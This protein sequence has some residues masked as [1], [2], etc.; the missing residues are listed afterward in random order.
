MEESL[1][2]LIL[3][4]QRGQRMVLRIEQEKTTST[5]VRTVGIKFW[6]AAA[7]G[8]DSSIS[9]RA[10]P[11]QFDLSRSYFAFGAQ[12]RPSAPSLISWRVFLLLSYSN[13]NIAGYIQSARSTADLFCRKSRASGGVPCRYANGRITCATDSEMCFQHRIP[14]HSSHRFIYWIFI[15]CTKYT[16]TC[17]LFPH[18]FF[19]II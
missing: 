6:I 2:R 5:G 4:I 13:R 3:K 17:D 8:S 15:R 16:L 10:T 18:S 7:S 9:I 14:D 12:M 11:M 1:I 19:L